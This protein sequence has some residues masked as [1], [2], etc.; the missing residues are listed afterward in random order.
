M[1]TGNGYFILQVPYYTHVTKFARCGS[2]QQ[3]NYSKFKAALPNPQ[4]VC[5]IGN[6]TM[7][8]TNQNTQ[9]TTQMT[10]AIIAANQRLALLRRQ[11]QRQ[12]RKRPLPPNRVWE[13]QQ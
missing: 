11:Y 13:V 10:P 8:T 1:L 12:K 2:L 7:A 9:Q 5:A 6:K 4:N 3:L